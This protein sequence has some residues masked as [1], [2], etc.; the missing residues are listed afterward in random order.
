ML[1]VNS[2]SF[3]RSQLSGLSSNELQDWF[4]KVKAL[5]TCRLEIFHAGPSKDRSTSTWL[6]AV[7]LPTVICFANGKL[8]L[9]THFNTFKNQLLFNCYY[10]TTAMI[11]FSL[12]FVF[13]QFTTSS[14]FHV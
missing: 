3:P 13:P 10:Y 1:N 9:S 12:T 14:S 4:K 11:I 7:D 6:S 2:N 8:T 5:I